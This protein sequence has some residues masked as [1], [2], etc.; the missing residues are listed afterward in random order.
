VKQK[1]AEQAVKQLS[2][3]TEPNPKNASD[4]CQICPS[5]LVVSQPVTAAKSL[6]PSMLQFRELADH[7]GNAPLDGGKGAFFGP[8]IGR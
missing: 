4:C 7:T 5:R 8:G 2:P 6:Q 1:D 3:T